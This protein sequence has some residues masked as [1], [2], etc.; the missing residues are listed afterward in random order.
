MSVVDRH[1]HRTA[2][3]AEERSAPE[4]RCI[5]TGEAR[6]A[7]Q[8][9]RFVVGPDETVVPDVAERLPGRGIWVGAERAALEKA[10]AKNL[11]SRAAKAKVT[12]PADLVDTVERLLEG[13]VADVLGL[14]R[15]AG[16]AVAGLEKAR[17]AAIR[18]DGGAV[19]LASD[20]G[21]DAAREARGIARGRPILVALDA[22]RLGQVFGRERAVHVFVD[23][24]RFAADLA[25]D[26]ARL[27]G[28]SR[29]Q[30]MN[31]RMKKSA[32]IGTDG[33]T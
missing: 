5:V 9:V 33:E 19:V 20:A 14:A 15:R 7:E 27:R 21:G 24:D 1:R 30:A 32:P 12:V 23:G 29:G 22:A 3:A 26:I 16:R 25:R 18:T 6:P 31:G 17:S 2:A 11:F 13:R 4:R 28:L 8:M 10:V